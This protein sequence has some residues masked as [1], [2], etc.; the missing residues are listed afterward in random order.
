MVNQIL[1]AVKRITKN[2]IPQKY[3]TK[4]QPIITVEFAMPQTSIFLKMI[5]RIN[6]NKC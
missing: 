1:G 3:Y 2:R 5:V 6:R 4:H